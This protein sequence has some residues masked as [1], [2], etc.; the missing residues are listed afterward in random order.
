MTIRLPSTGMDD[1]VLRLAQL[2][3]ED[4]GAERKFQTWVDE[5]A[6]RPEFSDEHAA[7]AQSLWKN[8]HVPAASKQ[9]ADDLVR[10][11]YLDDK[12]DGAY[13]ATFPSGG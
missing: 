9:L 1:P 5:I 3:V 8:E 13:R 11:G 10:Y 6:G 2:V 12:G 7:L 4:Q